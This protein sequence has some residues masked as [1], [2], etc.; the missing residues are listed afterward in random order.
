MKIKLVGY[1]DDGESV[2]ISN[3]EAG[4]DSIFQKVSGALEEY[5]KIHS[6]LQ[7]CKLCG[8]K[9]QELRDGICRECFNNK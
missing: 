7:E 1:D 6:V 9:V 2:L 5:V 4:E 8:S 3:I